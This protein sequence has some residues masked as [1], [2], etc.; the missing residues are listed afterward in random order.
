M[1]LLALVVSMTI[2]SEK[3]TTIK[4]EDWVP[5]QVCNTKIHTRT[6]SERHDEMVRASIPGVAVGMLVNPAVGATMVGVSSGKAKEKFEK[7]KTT[8][9][10][11]CHTAYQFQWKQV[12][13][14]SVKYRG[15][16]FTSDVTFQ[17]RCPNGDIEYLKR[18]IK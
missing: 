13:A 14:C 5:V 8:E 2:I 17:G 10:T 16:L 1:S 7:T 15:I 4:V 3:P 11:N 12:P 18:K 6:P 9:T